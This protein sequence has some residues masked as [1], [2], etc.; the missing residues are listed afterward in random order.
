MAELGKP[1]AIHWCAGSQQ[2]YAR[3]GNGARAEV[4]P[5]MIYERELR[6]CRL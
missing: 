4:P 3:L 2:E 6:I 1:D 5:E